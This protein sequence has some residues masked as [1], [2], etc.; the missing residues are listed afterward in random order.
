VR[1]SFNRVTAVTDPC[2]DLVHRGLHVIKS[3]GLMARIIL[4]GPADNGPESGECRD[5]GFCRGAGDGN[6]TRTISLGSLWRCSVATC[7]LLTCGS[8]DLFRQGFGDQRDMGQRRSEGPARLSASD[9]DGPW[10]TTPI[11]QRGT[12][13]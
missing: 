8:A 1:E 5:L 6:R 11:G 7:R 3:R 2:P 13:T 12:A 10:S 4:Q 9:R